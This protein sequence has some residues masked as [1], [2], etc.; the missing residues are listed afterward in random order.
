MAGI[1][2]F[3]L[4]SSPAAIRQIFIG[5]P[6]VLHGGETSE[7]L[8]PVVGTYSLLRLDEA[9]HVR[10]RKLLLPPFHGERMQAYAEVMREAT[11]AAIDRWPL[12]EPFAMHGPMQEITLAVILRA[13]FGLTDSRRTDALASLLTE[14]LDCAQ[15]PWVLLEVFQRDWPG[16]PWRKFLRLRAQIDEALFAE[17]ARRR[18]EGTAGEART[19]ILALLLAARREDG[20]G[21]SDRELR[22]ELMT[23]LVA[24]HETTASTLA[25]TFE[26]M[27]ANPSVLARAQSEIARVVGDGPLS[28][29]HLPRL[30]YL[31]AVVKETLRLRPIL[32][33]TARKTTAPVEIGGYQIPARELVGA[34]IY[35]A[36]LREE[37][38]PEPEAFRPERWE[39]IKPDPY[40][41]LPFGGGA[42][43]CIGM[44]FAQYEMKVVL[45]AT[46]ARARLRLA[47]GRDTRVVRRGITLVPSGGTRVV[48][49][50][51]TPR[52]TG[53]GSAREGSAKG[54]GAAEAASAG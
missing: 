36:H 23:M 47:P 31:D 5:D 1:G 41:W 16:T 9:E 35:L 24:G 10:E 25:W 48:L 44:A 50:A 38:F 39:G 22:D 15:T 3:A 12:G 17:I 37:S 52:R 7:P 13:V 54:Q 34:C 40:T 53:Q 49:D 26:R 43:R 30:E 4:F 19:D 27:L 11:D 33:L 20:S 51:R 21:M 42:R 32:P 29:A 14:L 8:A 46:L 18:A 2:R 45:A 28:P 6:A